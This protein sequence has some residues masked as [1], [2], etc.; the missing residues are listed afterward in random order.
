MD[1]LGNWPLDAEAVG[2]YRR[3]RLRSRDFYEP[4]KCPVEASQYAWN[5]PS[6]CGIEPRVGSSPAESAAGRLTASQ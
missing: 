6:H 3:N 1:W 4:A 5:F 2:R